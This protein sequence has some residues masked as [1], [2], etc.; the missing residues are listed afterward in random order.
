MLTKLI[1]PHSI[2]MPSFTSQDLIVIFSKTVFFN[3]DYT[4]IYI[5]LKA[6]DFFF[7]KKDNSKD[8]PCIRVG[9]YGF[10]IILFGKQLGALAAYLYYSVHV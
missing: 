5:Y 4:Y 1:L 7:F 8:N 10:L 6:I 2:M 3:I 9:L